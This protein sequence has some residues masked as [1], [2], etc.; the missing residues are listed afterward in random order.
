MIKKDLVFQLYQDHGGMPVNEVEAMTNSLLNL[1][2][3]IL[4]R[5]EPLTITH[6]GKFQYKKRRV[7]E[8]T[9]PNG[10]KQL[11]SSSDRLQFLP[12]TGLKN[13]INSDHQELET[14]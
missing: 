10:K 4:E 2:T 14:K 1:M 3:E 5:R 7:R 8:I 9:L 6:F 12:S 13:A 11:S